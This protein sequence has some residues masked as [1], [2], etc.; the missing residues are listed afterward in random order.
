[1]VVDYRVINAPTTERKTERQKERV[2]EWVREEVT[3]RDTIYLKIY[4]L[5]VNIIRYDNFLGQNTLQRIFPCYVTKLK[6]EIP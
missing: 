6:K 4:D 5:L 3:Y 2:S 1:M